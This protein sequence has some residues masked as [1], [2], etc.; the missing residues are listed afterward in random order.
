MPLF[1][2][3]ARNKQ[4]TKLTGDMQ[5]GS[6]Q[7]VARQLNKNGITPVEINFVK[8]PQTSVSWRKKLETPNPTEL[9]TFCHQMFTLMKAGVPIIRALRSL[10]KS[11]HNSSLSIILSNIITNLE[12]GQ[13][14]STALSHHP[15]VF[16]NLFVNIIRIGE[17]T[18][19]LD[20]AFLR[21]AKYLELEKT[22]KLKFGLLLI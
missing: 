13:P 1:H 14:L 17:N 8:K 10:A 22:A 11:E 18:G 15:T 21:I 9:I 16:S 20:Q 2:Y 6:C 4:G 7:E 3:T 19:S 5:A 12:M